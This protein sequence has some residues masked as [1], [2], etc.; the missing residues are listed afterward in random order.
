MIKRYIVTLIAVL[1]IFTPVRVF[2]VEENNAFNEGTEEGIYN[3]VPQ[4]EELPYDNTYEAPN[5]GENNWNNGY[6]NNGAV[7]DGMWNDGDKGTDGNTD[8][9]GYQNQYTAPE[10]YE[11]PYTAPYTEEEIET[12]EAPYEETTVYTAPEVYEAPY[13]KPVAESEVSEA[14]KTLSINTVKREG[15]TVSGVV[16]GEGQPADNVKL[17]LA[18]DNESIETASNENGEF[19]FEDVANGTYTLS[20]ADS[21]VFEASAEPVEVT[22]E[23]RNKLGYKIEVTS[24]GQSPVKEGKP[25]ETKEVEEPPVEEAKTNEQ[26]SSASN[27]MSLF[28]LI[29]IAGGTLLLLAAIGISLFR[30]LSER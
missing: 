16:T 7:E 14:D 15:Y 1:I 23:N 2:A 25:E 20:V 13:T 6:E 5:Y 26:S 30:K 11:D 17:L 12:Y 28:E 9:D 18:T 8:N 4:Q 3:E 21:E 27:G 24:I 22:V 29:L 10:V 19:T